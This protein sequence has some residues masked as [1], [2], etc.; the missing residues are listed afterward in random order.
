VSPLSTSSVEAVGAGD[1][2]AED[3]TVSVSAASS[4]RT[5]S[6]DDDLAVT[7]WPKDIAVK[8]TEESFGEL[9]IP[10]GVRDETFLIRR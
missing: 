6:E 4:S 5:S 8:V 9:I 7:G 10:Q 2:I 3:G 1:V